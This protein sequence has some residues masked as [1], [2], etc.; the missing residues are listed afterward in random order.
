M[1]SS[2][3]DDR[4]NF[5]NRLLEGHFIGDAFEDELFNHDNQTR[6]V[7]C[8]WKIMRSPQYQVLAMGAMWRWRAVGIPLNLLDP[9]EQGD[10]DILLKLRDRKGGRFVD[11]TRCF[12]L[13]T[14]KV[15]R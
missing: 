15:K 6:E 5:A 3:D 9:G 13:K 7:A 11:A 2:S 4:A 12:E 1:T 8:A 10:I 14:A